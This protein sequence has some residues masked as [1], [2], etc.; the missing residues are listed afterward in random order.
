MKNKK[1]LILRPEISSVAPIYSLLP[2]IGDEQALHEHGES[3]FA[4]F[5]RAKAALDELSTNKILDDKLINNQSQNSAD[6]VRQ[7]RQRLTAEVGMLGV[8]LKFLDYE[9]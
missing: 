5:E 3:M 1:S 9:I 4:R 7:Q 2:D 8:V 6:F